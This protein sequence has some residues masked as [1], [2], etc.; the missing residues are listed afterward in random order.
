M[1]KRKVQLA[2]DTG[3]FSIW[4]QP[5]TGQ[6]AQYK[7]QCVDEMQNMYRTIYSVTTQHITICKEQLGEKYTYLHLCVKLIQI[8]MIPPEITSD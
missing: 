1:K 5:P 7:K 3:A 4:G 2:A 6:S 8:N